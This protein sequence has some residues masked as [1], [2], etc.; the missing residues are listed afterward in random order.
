MSCTSFLDTYHTREILFMSVDSEWMPES[1]LVNRIVRG[2]KQ[3]LAELFSLNRDR[4][5]RMV[6]FRLDRHLYGRIDAD[7]V[8][9]EAYLNAAQR[10]GYFITEASQSCFVWLR[11]IVSQTLIDIHR[12]H[13]GTQRRD[14]NRE[15]S[16]H[17]GWDS[18][19][20][21]FSLSF[22]LLAHLTSP[23]QA[24]VRAELSEQLDT[25]LGTISD[26][27]REVLVLRHFEELT[28]RETAL[29]LN[30]T[31]QAAS[32]RYIRALGRLKD[33]MAAIAGTTND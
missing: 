1:A 25:A 20:T 5:W 19:S 32:I 24:A 27:D 3:A 7:D 22:H 9:Q 15:V 10:I 11:M 29:V 33:V 16:I 2:D 21:S 4:L 18:Q 13:L 6:N 28:N 17:G 30:I 31:A 8:L 23:S 26:L 12:R 14:A